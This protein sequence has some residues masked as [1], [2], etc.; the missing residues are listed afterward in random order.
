MRILVLGASGMLGS[1]LVPYLIEQGREVLVASRNHVSGIQIDLQDEAAT[2]AVV[3][4]IMPEVTI[5]LVGMTDVERCESHPK[6]AWHANVRSAENIANAIGAIGGHL[7]HVSTDQVY[8]SA[9]ACLEANACPGNHYAIT[10]YA[11]EL[12]ALRAGASVLRT[13][14]FGVSSHATR[15]SFTDWIFTAL[16]SGRPIRVFDDVRFSPLD[17]NTLC[18]MINEVIQYRHSGVFN[19]GSCDGMSKADFAFAFADALGLPSKRLSRVSAQ[20]SGLLN[21][22]RPKNMCMDSSHFE[23][24][25]KVS[26]PT[27]Q[28]EIERS[29]RD[30]RGQI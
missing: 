1:R 8:D 6:Q 24:T 23:V 28:T 2:L 22:W 4:S 25:F 19:L 16:K 12:A 27:L 20:Q 3:R 29:A 18:Q 9:P 5:N 21:T 26:L 14:F 7:V 10:K 17:M 15:R 30:Y 13:N 11:G